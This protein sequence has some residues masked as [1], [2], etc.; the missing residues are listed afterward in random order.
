MKHPALVRVFAVVLAILG[1]IFL[2][3]GVR[4]L[5]K[6]SKEQAEREA[7][8]KK[9]ADRLENYVR[10]HEK[11]ENS[12]DYEE[13]RAALNRV[14][15]A[16]EKAAAQHKTD[17]AIFS[18]TKGGLKMGEDLIAGAQAQMEEIKRQLHDANDRKVFLEGLLSGLI[19]SNKSRMPWLDALA[20]SAAG[21]AV[22]CYTES[23]KITL[24]TEKLRALMEAEPSPFDYAAPVYAPPEAPAMPVFGGF[25]MGGSWEQMQ[26]GWDAAMAQAQSAAAAYEEAGAL[27]AQQMQDYYDGLAQAEF[28]R[29]NG[30]AERA[31]DFAV[32]MA[33]SAEYQWAH[34][35]WEKECRN[36][37]KEADLLCS[38]NAM[39]RLGTALSSLVRQANSHD[40]AMTAETGGYYPGFE[41]LSS[42]SASTAARLEGPGRSDL[43]GLSNEEFLLL[44]DEAKEVVDLL[45]SAFCVVADNLNN[46]SALI[47]ELLDK[48]HVTELI[49]KLADSLLAKAEQQMDTALAELWY[50]LGE[51]EKKELELAAEKLGLDEEAK[52][53]AKQTLEAD[54]LKE[55]NQKH[56]SAR[57][58]LSNVPEVKSGVEQGSDLPDSARA[59][60]E[61][62]REETGR[63]GTIRLILCG[64]AILGGAIALAEIPAA[65]E[66]VKS[67]FLLLAPA[68]V[69]LV[70]AV[71][72]FGLNEL[73][74]L[75]R[76]YAALLMA[77]F[78]L[79]YL[80]IAAPKSKQA[81]RMPQHLK[82]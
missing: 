11:L 2:A 38:V 51:Q 76:Y 74:G 58:L 5:G 37:K 66:F 15:T 8:E 68:V 30:F 61:A 59:Y 41:E 6:N 73:L 77:V 75:K 50:Q 39:R 16:H 24:I 70:C 52:I 13:T 62:Y 80:A 31:E 28:D 18:A 71:G 19:A 53:L 60:L 17:T 54:E 63:R 33:Y 7:Y 22:D 44:F 9:F 81:R 4:G 14:L 64:L 32:D 26:A 79:A 78:A 10:L 27:Y 1:V 35:A 46:P 23:A 42:L 3:T 65:F 45:C 48:L 67:R 21:Y 20:N 55:L 25:D 72:A 29:L 57:L 56:T 34:D 47:V 43:S 40:A 69:C 49:A 82:V 12:A 36:V